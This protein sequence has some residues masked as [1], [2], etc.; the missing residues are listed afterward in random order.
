MTVSVCVHTSKWCMHLWGFW[1]TTDPIGPAEGPIHTGNL[2]YQKK[3]RL[4]PR[5]RHTLLPHFT[6]LHWDTENSTHEAEASLA[7]RM[8]FRTATATPKNPASKKNSS[9]Y[10]S[11]E[12][13]FDSSTSTGAHNH[14]TSVPGDL[15]PS[16]VLWALGTYVVHRYTCR[17]Y[18]NFKFYIHICM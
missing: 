9:G 16:S 18:T 14:L 13:S 17:Q 15:T 12:L 2:A 5:A 3:Q 7:Y 1:E 6:S 11:R 4:E 8:R 10:S